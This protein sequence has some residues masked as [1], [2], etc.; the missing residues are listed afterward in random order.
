M[1]IRRVLFPSVALLVLA[2]SVMVAEAQTGPVDGSKDNKGFGQPGPV[3]GRLITAD[4]IVSLLQ[5][6]GFKAQLLPEI[7][8]VKTVF[9]HM[10]VGGWQYDVNISLSPDGRLMHFYSPV[11]MPG[12]SLTQAQMQALLQK[13]VELIF[14]VKTFGISPQDGRV[15]LLNV[16]YPTNSTDQ[17]FY[18]ILDD[19]LTTIRGTY[20]LWKMP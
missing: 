19:H 15:Y 8:G 18:Q 13:N 9:T 3:Q 2:G 10:E 6:K 16:S 12:Q 7:K 5:N 17:Q 20:D 14:G 4:K 1:F 11:T